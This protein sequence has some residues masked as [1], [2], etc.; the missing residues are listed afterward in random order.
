MNHIGSK[1]N[2]PQAL[3]QNLTEYT[4]S[5][6]F[7]IVELSFPTPPFSMLPPNST[8]FTGGKASRKAGVEATNW[9]ALVLVERG[10]A[11]TWHIRY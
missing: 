11:H 4:N 9:I 6:S 2:P 5:F 10:S 3:K 1:K 7:R 8:D